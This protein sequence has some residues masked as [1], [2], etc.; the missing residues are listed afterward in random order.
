MAAYHA[1]T[2]LPTTHYDAGA[3]QATLNEQHVQQY[4]RNAFHPLTHGSLFADLPSALRQMAD[5]I[6][7]SGK[8][9]K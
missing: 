4:F 8:G 9:G 1:F 6:E 7:K 3:N 2:P 5:I